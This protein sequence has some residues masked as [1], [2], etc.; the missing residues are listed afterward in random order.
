MAKKKM[1][2]KNNTEKAIK[3][4]IPLQVNL[5]VRVNV[6]G[7][8]FAN[9]K[10]TPTITA[11]IITE[12]TKNKTNSKNKDKISIKLSINIIRKK[13]NEIL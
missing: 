11:R 2:K 5:F 10:T 4:H 8:L 6:L 3:N 13:I 12:I 7:I 1:K 9:V